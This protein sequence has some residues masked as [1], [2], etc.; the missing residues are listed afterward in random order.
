[1]WSE[2][3][4]CSTTCGNGEKTRNRTCQNIKSPDVCDSLTNQTQGCFLHGCPGKKSC[5]IQLAVATNTKHCLSQTVITL[6]IYVSTDSRFGQTLENKWCGAASHGFYGSFR[7]ATNACLSDADC[8][9]V[10]DAGCAGKSFKL[11][12]L[13]RKKI[14]P[15]PTGSC[16][17]VRKGNILKFST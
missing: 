1:M 13:K 8:F 3:S 15:D 10:D 11:C 2:W 6:I 16:I 4:D 17:F 7:E 5:F 14:E 12:N 9:G